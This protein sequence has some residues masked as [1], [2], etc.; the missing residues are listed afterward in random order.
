[1]ENRETNPPSSRGDKMRVLVAE[2]CDDLRE[3]LID[4]LR[5]D[6]F[7]V[8]GARS[9]DQALGLLGL[10][11]GDKEHRRYDAVV[12]DLVMPDGGGFDVLERLR[13]AH[14]NVPVVLMSGHADQAAQDR[15]RRLG[16]AML[17]EKPLTPSTLRN[18][19]RKVLDPD[20]W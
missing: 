1:M 13:S 10:R 9:G 6:G 5:G 14:S 17:L 8:T 3:L 18:A 2:D 4:V 16:A 7:S 20:W 15:A 12:S 19:V 11:P